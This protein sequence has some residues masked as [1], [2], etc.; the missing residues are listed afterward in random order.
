MTISPG[1]QRVAL[2]ALCTLLSS[3]AFAAIVPLYDRDDCFALSG[4]WKTTQQSGGPLD[5]CTLPAGFT[6]FSGDRLEV[7]PSVELVVTNNSYLHVDGSLHL[8]RRSAMSATARGVIRVNGTLEMRGSTRLTLN[9][10]S[11]DNRGI[12]R[13]EGKIENGKGTGTTQT[14]GVFNAGHI[15][16]FSGGEVINEG[17]FV[18]V[19]P[20]IS[21]MKSVLVDR[22]A[23][24]VNKKGAR[25]HARDVLIH[26]EFVNEWGAEI[27]SRQRVEI[28]S[29]GRLENAGHILLWDREFGRLTIQNGG[30]LI[31]SIGGYITN[32]GATV[33]IRGTLHQKSSTF[34][35]TNG[36][37]IETHA[38]SLLRVSGKS[39][40]I[41]DAGATIHNMGWIKI[42]CFSIFT[43]NGS[44]IGN[45]I[46]TPS[47][48]QPPIDPPPV[49]NWSW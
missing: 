30:S 44:L 34:H 47:C 38:G 10:G 25:M 11:L 22:D 48:F 17:E 18:D 20:Q 42:E 5:T 40:L 24:F 37:T 1:I 26:G 7:G 36:G 31:S 16:L 23:K 3:A 45:F 12:V 43:N 35:N 21:S 9:E 15:Q 2:A 29:I 14:W 41:H 19:A 46:G 32:Y 8:L 27:A 39:F 6:V 33:A 28:S 13:A 49:I 4:M